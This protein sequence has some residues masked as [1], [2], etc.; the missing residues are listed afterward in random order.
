MRPI[1]RARESGDPYAVPYRYTAEYGSQA[2]RRALARD[3]Q[4]KITRATLPSARGFVNRLAG[5]FRLRAQGLLDAQ[6]LIVLGQA[7]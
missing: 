7:V 1:G 4:P 6:E 3:G 5:K 2:S